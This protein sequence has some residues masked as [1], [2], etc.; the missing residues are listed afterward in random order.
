MYIYICM[1]VFML[2]SVGMQLKLNSYGVDGSKGLK[3]GTKNSELL[4][5]GF[6]VN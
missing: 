4:V 1:Y 5:T 6:D 2:G 3:A